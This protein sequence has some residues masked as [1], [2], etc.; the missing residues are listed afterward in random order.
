LNPVEEIFYSGGS[1]GTIMNHRHVISN[2][3]FEKMN[4]KKYRE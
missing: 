3:V 2:A 1:Y 4:C